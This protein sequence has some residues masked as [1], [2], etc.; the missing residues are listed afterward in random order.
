VQRRPYRD[1]DLGRLQGVLQGWIGEQGRCGY[2]HSGVLPH[3]IY[4][5]LR[6][7][8]PVGDLVHI[9]ADGPE[10]VGLSICLRFGCAFDVF[11]APRLRGTT[12]EDELLE[13]A[14]RTT[15]RF[16]EPAEEYILTDVFGADQA[17]RAAL[18][19]VGFT[20]Y[21]VWDD[22]RERS[23]EIPIGQSTVDGFV[24]R[25]ATVDD[26]E[27]LAA[28]RNASFAPAWTGEQY[29]R[30]VMDK[31]GYDPDREIVA[32]APDGRIAAYAV[33][34]SDTRNRL[35]LFEPV[36]THRD[37]RRLGLGQAVMRHAMDR[38]RAAGLTSVSVNHNEDNVAARRLY[39]S[40]GFVRTD[41]TYGYRRPSE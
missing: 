19:K 35:G 23:L 28:A 38:M 11:L 10:V 2:D 32:V 29:R 36:G 41:R 33:Y 9:W 14:Y 25:P 24:V 4:E 13:D 6:G 21:R 3:R 17:R 37:F 7:R 8:R 18:A 1:E 12:V 31:P 39:E 27:G 40:L 5:N 34:W 15:A 20:E 16:A 30:E 26:A 22:V